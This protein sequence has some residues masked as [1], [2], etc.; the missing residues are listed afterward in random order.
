VEKF[1]NRLK[2]L[3]Q[4]RELS[5]AEVASKFNVTKGAVGLWE[6]GKRSPSISVLQ[7]MANF[8][9]VTLEYLTGSADNRIYTADESGENINLSA[10][11]IELLRLYDMLER[12]GKEIV[13]NVI[14]EMIEKMTPKVGSVEIEYHIDKNNGSLQLRL[15]FYMENRITEKSE[16]GFFLFGRV[17]EPTKNKEVLIDFSISQEIL[18]NF[19][20]AFMEQAEK[21]LK[22]FRSREDGIIKLEAIIIEQLRIALNG[23]EK[24][25]L[26]SEDKNIN[27]KWA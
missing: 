18:N 27:F 23:N 22:A 16:K 15:D 1:N 17:N 9:G 26:L 20:P 3:R 19:L 6:S 5:Q 11:E 4:E 12:V 10:D 14:K 25:Y 13:I 21:T 8:Y 2:T 24:E 7:Q